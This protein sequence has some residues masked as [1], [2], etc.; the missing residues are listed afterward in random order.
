MIKLAQAM[1]RNDCG[2]LNMIFH[3][4]S[5]QAGLT[6]FTRTKGDE[7]RLFAHLREFLVFA[8]D[9]GIESIRLSEIRNE[10]WLQPSP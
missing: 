3:S 2:V 1:M 6:P 9:A 8:R 10:L 4:P 7:K 5:L